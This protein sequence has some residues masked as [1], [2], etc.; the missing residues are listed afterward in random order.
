MLK[1]YQDRLSQ[2]RQSH[3]ISQADFEA[4]RLNPLTI[5]LFED[6]EL[7]PLAISE[8]ITANDAGTAGL[9]AAKLNGVQDTAEYAIDWTPEY[10]INKEGDE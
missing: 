2:T 8:T 6:L 7:L 4:W 5:Q 1:D 9:Q 10:L 3:P